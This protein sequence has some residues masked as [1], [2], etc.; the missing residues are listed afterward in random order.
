[1]NAELASQAL[2]LW[3]SMT[4]GPLLVASS[5]RARRQRAASALRASSEELE[6]EGCEVHLVRPCAGSEPELFRS[7]SSLPET[8]GARLLVSF[9][10][11][12]E[13]DPARPAIEAALVSLRARGVEGRLVISRA[14]GP[15]RKV[16]QILAALRASS[17]GETDAQIVLVA[18]S[19]VDLAGYPL[20]ELV[21]PLERDA[22]VGAV[23]APPHEAGRPSSPGDLASGALLGASLHSF[24]LLAEL[25]PAG[26]VG[27]CFAA[28][29]TT[30]MRTVRL[31]EL[32]R[33]LGED[34]ELSRRL[35]AQGAKIEVAATGVRSLASGRQLGATVERFGRWLAVIRA[36]R[37]TL[38]VSYPL[39]F[40]PLLSIAALGLLLATP[41][42]FAAI[43]VALVVRIATAWAAR[44][45]TS[46]STRLVDLLRDVGL[47]EA[48]LASAW[49]RALSSRRFAWRERWMRLG[50]DGRLLAADTP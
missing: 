21:L 15:N 45:A 14:A 29:R 16:Q 27:K 28:R 23:W 5:R 31:D 42:A 10:I 9:C 46:G 30:L 24:A 33:Y 11:E 17:S 19:D 40:F 8:S 38:L 26:L 1:M 25:D 3:A 39:M 50:P 49:L 48:T 12:R 35:C 20:S 37:P 2:L 18:D 43:G 32:D 47:A 13:D 41:L 6:L 36:Q 44:R 7:L 4:A 22:R 34:M